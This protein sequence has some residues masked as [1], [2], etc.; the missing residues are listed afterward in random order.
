MFYFCQ[1]IFVWKVLTGN[2]AQWYIHWAG[3]Y[4]FIILLSVIISTFLRIS[5]NLLPNNDFF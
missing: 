2:F 5:G 4:H 1:R 3:G